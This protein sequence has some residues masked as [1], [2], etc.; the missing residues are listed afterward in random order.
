VVTDATVQCKS[1]ALAAGEVGSAITLPVVTSSCNVTLDPKGQPV[2]DSTY[3][4]GCE[5][6][7]TY[8]YTY[9]DCSGHDTTWTF[10]YHIVRTTPPAEVGGPVATTETVQTLADAR[11]R[12]ASIVK[13]TVKDYCGVTLDVASVDTTDARID[14]CLR[15]RAYTFTY[16]DCVDSVFQWTYTFILHDVTAPVVS[17]A[18]SEG[19]SGLQLNRRLTSDNCKFLVPAFIDT[20]R[21][22]S[23]DNVLS[24]AELIITQDSVAGT[25]LAQYDEERTVPVTVT[26]ADSC[27]NTTSVV[28]QLTVPARLRVEEI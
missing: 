10:T 4:T 17:V 25:E 23:S 8:T 12:F 15:S 28:F 5:G 19:T 3:I 13:P 20:V 21:K 2:K 9:E 16:R 24:R 18:E 14:E 27:G 6:D 22:Y 7:I 11:G 1:E 26:V